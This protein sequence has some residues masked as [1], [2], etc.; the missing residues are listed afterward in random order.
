MALQ[1]KSFAHL[2]LIFIVLFSIYLYEYDQSFYQTVKTSSLASSTIKIKSNVTVVGHNDDDSNNEETMGQNPIHYHNNDNKSGEDY[3]QQVTK[4]NGTV[5][6]VLS[7]TDANMNENDSNDNNI[8]ITNEDENGDAQINMIN[9]T[10]TGNNDDNDDV[11][12]SWDNS[13]FRDILERRQHSSSNIQV[14]LPNNMTGEVLH[15]GQLVVNLINSTDHM[16]WYCGQSNLCNL[17][18]LMTL[19]DTIPEDIDH[20]AELPRRPLLNY[21]FACNDYF[22]PNNR[23]GLGEGNWVTAVYNTRLTAAAARV[24]FQFNCYEGNNHQ[25][26]RLLPWLQTYQSAPL[27]SNLW[28]Y[29]GHLPTHDEACTNLYR[30]IRVDFMI[31]EIM[32]DMQK[33]AVTLIGPSNDKSHPDVP[34]EQPPLI[35]G[36]EVEDVVIHFRCGDILGAVNR[37]DFGIMKFSEY[38]KWISKDTRTI[39][40]VTQPFDKDLNREADMGRVDACRSVTYLLVE[41]LQNFLPSAKISIHNDKNETLPLTYARLTMANQSFTT[42]S[43]FG[44]FPVIGGFGRGYF[45]RGNRGVNPFVS[46][47]PEYYPDKLFMM[48]G[49][50][51]TSSQILK[52]GLP[53]VEK[54]LVESKQNGTVENQSSE[55]DA[56]INLNDNNDNN[57]IITNEDENG[58]AQINMINVTETGNNDDND[59][60]LYSWDNSTFRDI[61]ERRQH[62]SSNIQVILPNN[63]TGEVLHDG[64]LVVNLINSTDHMLWYCGQ[65]NLCNLLQLMTLSDT[66]PEDIDHAAELPR[67]PLL[68]YTFACN[69]YFDPNNR[70]GLGE[71]NWVTA[72]YNTR[73]TAAAARVDFQFNCYEGN[74]HQMRRL[75]PWLQTY[76]SAPLASNLWPYKGHLPTHDEACTNLYRRIRVDFMI[77]EIMYDMQKMAVTLIGPSNDKSHP[78]VPIEQPPLIPGI[79]VEDVVIHFRCGDILGAVNRNDFGIMK[80][81]E[82]EKW[83]SKDTR[84]IGIVTQP[85]DKDL[86]READMGRVDACRSVTYLLVEKLQNF[87]PSA[88]ISIHNDKNETLPLTYAR[89]TMANQSFTTLSSFGIFPVIGGFGRG[90]FQRGNRGVNPFV[91]HLPE[92]YPDKLFMME[93]EIMTSSQIRKQGLPFVEKWLVE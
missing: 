38:E 42:L 22:D 92:Y 28:P 88:K 66:I 45:Q 61:L 51:M 39:G 37:N 89:L 90:Y 10:E 30:R 78:D 53:F 15:D 91:S 35:P 65:S 75:L 29:K 47:L 25:M 43:S 56:S 44:I 1:R 20:A 86:N 68:N 63:M 4:Q 36:I 14:I 85:F 5:E 49:E 83:I 18:Q 41:K 23:W 93:G 84:T 24:D 16:L 3:L 81:S 9:V 80:F 11:L 73:L 34:I 33:M 70:W 60:V 71:G 32:Y 6:N 17:L 72:V 54:W 76:Q 87:L 55:T 74:N 64:Q 62:S 27:A 19:S 57:I 52:Q 46:H 12:Y 69:D 50:I 77:D 7:E 82:Y 21:T 2:F 31:D 13:T 8:I 67:R 48:E 26:R 58:D 59:D 79:E 40:I